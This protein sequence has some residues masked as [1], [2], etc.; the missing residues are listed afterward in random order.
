MIYLIR[1]GLTEW[2]EKSFFRGRKDIPLSPAGRTQAHLVG[3]FFTTRPVAVVYTSPLKRAYE[4][5]MIIANQIGCEVQVIEELTDINF[6]EWEGKPL[7]WVKENYPFEYAQY[8]KHPDSV[9]IPGGESLDSCRKRASRAFLTTVK[10]SS[11]ELEENRAVDLNNPELAFVSHRVIIKL[12]LLEALGLS[13]DFFWR[14]HIDTCGINE[15]EYSEIGF[16][17][18]RMNSVAH[19]KED[20]R[21]RGDF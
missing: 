12:L 6:G 11:R 13:T 7:E 21:G 17:I 19:L 16:V 9:I 4:T 5:S 14:I 8:K 3:E 10:T 20:E 18:H 2:N 15:L 1:H